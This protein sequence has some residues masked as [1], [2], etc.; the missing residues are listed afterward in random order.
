MDLE[1]IREELEGYSTKVKIFGHQRYKEHVFL[2][3]KIL[4]EIKKKGIMKVGLMSFKD[5]DAERIDELTVSE[6]ISLVRHFPAWSRN[7]KGHKCYQLRECLIERIVETIEKANELNPDITDLNSISGS[8]SLNILDDMKEK[9]DIRNENLAKAKDKLLSSIEELHPNLDNFEELSFKALNGQLAI[10]M[11]EEMLFLV[12]ESERGANQKENVKE[13]KT[14]IKREYGY[15]GKNQR[16]AAKYK[17]EVT[18]ENGL[19]SQW[20]DIN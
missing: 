8:M 5:Y 10:G 18:I 17:T 13:G 4:K 19:V 12:F 7:G 1:Q 14:I 15:L 3:R 16:G 11:P 9:E 6:M 20:R 2:D